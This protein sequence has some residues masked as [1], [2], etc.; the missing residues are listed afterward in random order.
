MSESR[1]AGRETERRDV[2]AFYDAYKT[3]GEGNAV[4]RPD[5][6][7]FSHV[8]KETKRRDRELLKKKQNRPGM[9]IQRETGPDAFA[10]ENF[11]TTMSQ[12][13]RWFG[14]ELTPTTEFDDWIS[15]ADAIVEWPGDGEP[16]RLAID[17]TAAEDIETFFR[18]SDKL[19]GNVRLKY[20]RSAVEEEDGRPKEL[21]AFMPLVL[22]GFDQSVY[23]SIAERKD[24]PDEHHPIRRLL[25][26]QA[27]SQIDLQ[28]RLLIEKA[29]ESPRAKRSKKLEGALQNYR[30]LGKDFTTTQ[31]I[32]FISTLDEREIDAVLNAKNKQRL[33]DLLRV[34]GQLTKE[35]ER[36]QE[37]ELNEEWKRI[38]EQSKTHQILSG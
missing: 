16:V 15:G 36:A 9:R 7:S 28:L 5:I 17:F 11:L 19:E 21:R 10:F 12:E 20:V 23:R 26:E 14:G 3:A 32:D 29:F 6:D 31:T 18:K 2:W 4:P 22:L 1:N 37:I 27:A 8:D 24:D 25:I 35:T 33:G 30:S 13:H 34:K 38:A